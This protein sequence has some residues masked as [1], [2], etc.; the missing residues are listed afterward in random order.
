MFEFSVKEKVESALKV[1]LMSLSAF[2]NSLVLA[3]DCFFHIHEPFNVAVIAVE[4]SF[5]VILHAIMACNSD[6]AGL[7]F[8]HEVNPDNNEI[9]SIIA[10]R[11]KIR[12]HIDTKRMRSV[13]RKNIGWLLQRWVISTLFCRG[14]V[15]HKKS[16]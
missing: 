14:R 7:S 10:G 13:A 1:T 15:F 11:I 8:L 5:F 6:L 16:L 9:Y 2:L 12:F 3:M 4:S